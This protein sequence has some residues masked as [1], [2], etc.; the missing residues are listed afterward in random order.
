MNKD[1]SKAYI[2]SVLK[3]IET[4]EPLIF[5]IMVMVSLIPIFWFKIIPTL[6]GPAHLYNSNL[7]LEIL[8]DNYFIK[9]YYTFNSFPVPNWTSHLVLAFFNSFLPAYI[10]EKILQI[11]YIVGLAYS[12]RYFVLS[13]S[14]NYIMSFM[15]F[16]F[17]YSFFFFLGFWN[18]CL[19]LVVMFFSLGY[20]LRHKSKKRLEYSLFLMLLITIL[21]FSH[22]IVWGLFCIIFLILYFQEITVIIINEEKK[23]QKCLYKTLDRILLIIPS[24]ALG[25][26]YYLRGENG[27]VLYLQKNELNTMLLNMQS[28]I[29]INTFDQSKYTSILVYVIIFLFMT[30]IIM[31]IK[32]RKFYY[33][34]DI[35]LY[36]SVVFILL[37]FILPDS[38][39]GGGY[40]SLRMNY[41]FFIFFVVWFTTINFNKILQSF[42]AIFFCG[43]MIFSVQY[44]IKTDYIK[45]DAIMLSR[46]YE[47]S[48]HIPKNC[49]VFPKNNADKWIFGHYSNILGAD[50]A[51]VN[52]ENYESSTGYF[53]IVWNKDQDIET[54]LINDSIKKQL[55]YYF[56]IITKETDTLN[57]KKTYAFECLKKK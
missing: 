22:F 43:Y 14:K 2:K 13:L 55:I 38:M 56:N 44:I 36:I 54:K 33:R 25:F 29:G 6:D 41:I 48:K 11:I 16:A 24:A 10:A 17:L 27:N 52:L 32:E 21:Y 46:I 4:F 47:F 9:N 35:W 53:P 26:T 50:N 31:R 7:I 49:I 28:I 18:F 12:F 5:M 3:S 45:Q 23:I 30:S 1:S 39:Q 15:I 19:A 8:K 37:Y 51:I 20:Y 34:N 57:P 42:A 40:L